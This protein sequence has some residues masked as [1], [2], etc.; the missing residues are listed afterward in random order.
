M[1]LHSRP[2]Y[3]FCGMGDAQPDNCKVFVLPVP[4]DSTTF[5]RAGARDGP[6]AIISAS[7]NMELFDLELGC[8]ISKAGIH[9]L[10]ELE[11]SMDSPAKTVARVEDA[12]GEIVAAG[13][14]PVMLGGE[15]SVTVGAVRALKKSHPKMNV[16]QLDAHGDLRD[17][18]ED[19][20]HNHACTM[21]R[22]RE[23]CPAVQAGIRSMCEEEVEYVKKEKLRLF[24][25]RSFDAREILRG[26]GEEVYVTIDLDVFD[27]GIMPAVGSPE[28]G[29]LLWE[30]VLPLLAEVCAKRRVIGFDVMELAPAPGN[31]APDFLAAKL[32]Y[33]MIG[34]S[35]R[36]RGR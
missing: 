35:L 11:P 23:I 6:H 27:P 17:E 32:T 25:G 5:Y 33:K 30:E 19:S 1:L 8:D 22:V 26:L 7:R 24:Y 21:R 3:N 13:K 9:T 28:P 14:F 29:G 2:P 31:V 36:L 20:K 4:Y 10:D 34:Y 12:V 16:L 18:F 15:H